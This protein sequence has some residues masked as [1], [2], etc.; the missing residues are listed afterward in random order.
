VAAKYPAAY[1]P[2][3]NK[4]EIAV[5]E[6]HYRK[7]G[8]IEKIRFDRAHRGDQSCIGGS[9]AWRGGCRARVDAARCPRMAR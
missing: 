3:E 1:R 5:R 6:G 2:E 7:T 8:R 4:Q 9:E